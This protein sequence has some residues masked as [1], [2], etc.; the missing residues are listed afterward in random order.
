MWSVVHAEPFTQGRTP[1]TRR[2]H[3]ASSR[4]LAVIVRTSSTKCLACGSMPIHI[5]GSVAESDSGAT[6]G[7]PSIRAENVGEAKGRSFVW[8]EASNL[9]CN[10]ARRLR[11]FRKS[12]GCLVGR[13]SASAN[14]WCAPFD[15]A[16]LRQIAP[17]LRCPLDVGNCVVRS[18]CGDLPRHKRRGAACLLGSH[19][20]ARV[21]PGPAAV[22]VAQE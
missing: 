10:R 2:S 22:L 18:S 12:R 20:R 16:D 3:N 19:L 14:R 9:V 13:R 8:R 7:Q 5:T 17:N 21:F 4:R 15:P 6:G 1:L 11:K